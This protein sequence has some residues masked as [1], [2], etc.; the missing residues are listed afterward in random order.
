[1]RPGVRGA[2]PEL[3]LLDRS[4]ETPPVYTI[5]F[6]SFKG[7]V[8]R[9]MALVNVGLELVRRGRRVLLID[10]DLEA[11]GLTTYDVLRQQA[12]QAGVV[13]YVTE[14]IRTSQS[15]D[16]SRF[17]Y[18]VDLTRVLSRRKRREARERLPGDDHRKGSGQLW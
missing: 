8:G 5:T 7:G 3:D 6:Y 12:D 13:E 10:F 15:P 17:I 4:V 18:P 9:T 1:A 14:Y 2:L 11:P 16:V